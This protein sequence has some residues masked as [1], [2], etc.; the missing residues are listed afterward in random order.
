MCMHSVCT[1]YKPSNT[2]IEVVAIHRARM[3]S[4]HRK[5]HAHKRAFDRFIWQSILCAFFVLPS[6]C[7]AIVVA[8]AHCKSS[9][10]ETSTTSSLLVLVC[11]GFEIDLMALPFASAVYRCYFSELYSCHRSHSHS[12]SHSCARLLFHFVLGAFD[13][14][15]IVFVVVSVA[16]AWFH[17]LLVGCSLTHT[18][19]RFVIFECIR[20]W[21][22]MDC[23]ICT[24]LDDD[25]FE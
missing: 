25:R 14:V 2:S 24:P 15:S 21:D 4:S 10:S 9:E 1:V 20:H 17:S 18:C 23:S 8:A 7:S 5:L 6:I 22:A 16:S 11:C 19:L 13:A 12:H 3:T